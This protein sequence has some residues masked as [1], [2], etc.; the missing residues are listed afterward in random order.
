MLI[1]CENQSYD[2][3]HTVRRRPRRQ[4]IAVVAMTSWLYAYV[5]TRTFFFLSIIVNLKCNCFNRYTHL[6]Y[7]PIHCRDSRLIAAQNDHKHVSLSIKINNNNIVELTT[8]I[9][10]VCHLNAYW[11]NEQMNELKRKNNRIGEI[12]KKKHKHTFYRRCRFYFFHFFYFVCSISRCST[13][14]VLHTRFIFVNLIVYWTTGLT[15]LKW[16]CTTLV[17]RRVYLRCVFYSISHF[18]IISVSTSNLSLIIQTCNGKRRCAD[19]AFRSHFKNKK[20]CLKNKKKLNWFEQ[21]VVKWSVNILW[22]F[23]FILSE[24]FVYNF[25]SC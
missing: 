12:T 2:H 3:D 25:I 11:C 21:I 6:F 23:S 20:Y 1:D 10:Y 19:A 14:I 24:F 17:V 16:I 18:F 22:I 8:I 9:L 5:F 15:L 7:I 4:Q 13:Y